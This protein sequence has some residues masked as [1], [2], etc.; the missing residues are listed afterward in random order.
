MNKRIWKLY[1]ELRDLRK[2]VE[3][4]NNSL[5]Y[6][7]HEIKQRNYLITFLEDYGSVGSEKVIK[8]ENIICNV[9]D[10]LFSQP[11]F[12]QSGIEEISFQQ[13]KHFEQL[14][15]SIGLVL[16]KT[17]IVSERIFQGKDYK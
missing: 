7:N 17:T 6:A 2:R 8:V 4:L 13:Q 5:E 15:N 14:C 16:P 9:Y 3:A 11:V 10:S 1:K 12:R